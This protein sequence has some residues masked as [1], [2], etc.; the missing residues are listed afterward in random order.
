[1]PTYLYWGEEE[2]NLENA[3]R[4]LRKKVIDPGFSALSHKVL[5]EPDIKDL[6]EAAQTVP[7]M[8]GN[9]LIEVRTSSLFFRGKR[10]ISTSDPLM[11]KLIEV[12][13]RL[14]KRIHLLFVCPVERESGKK[15]DS[16]MKLVKTIQK[17]GEV[18][19]FPA[20]KFYQEDKIINWIIKQ[21]S[22]KSLKI[23]KNAAQS[24]LQNIGSDLRK[25]DLELEKIMTAV[26]P[27][28]TISL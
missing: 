4:E 19:E 18:D 10:S 16:V 2:F 7:M 6:L 27:L 13:E 3:V 9:L 5:N 15:I 8:L 11:Q 21:A 17:N 26:H 22:D 23:N 25:L 20:F 12:I 24:L 14:D 1:M 28:K